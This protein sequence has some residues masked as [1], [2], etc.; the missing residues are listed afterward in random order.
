MKQDLSQKLRQELRLSPQ[1]LE[2]VK[3]LQLPRLELQQMIRQELEVNPFLA[4]DAILEVEDEEYENEIKEERDEEE[5]EANLPK[6][7]EIDYDYFYHDEWK[8]TGYDFSK[9][10]SEDDEFNPVDVYSTPKSL[11]DYMLF[12]VH[13]NFEDPTDIKVAEFITDSLDEEGMLNPAKI[14]HES[15]VE[16]IAEALCTEVDAIPVSNGCV[17]IV[18]VLA[19]EFK[20]DMDRLESI[21][22][23]YRFLEPVGVGSRNVRESLLT[24][25][26]FKNMVDTPEY[27]IIRDCFDDF[28]SNKIYKIVLKLKM[29]DLTWEHKEDR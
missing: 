8:S 11:R 26:E 9:K 25:L 13:M 29:T 19:A 1:L 14:N 15:E 17:D 7:Q 4:D 16:K 22:K 6:E 21:L 3:I 23:R 18:Y 28:I 5:N 10:S 24:Q 2:L 12:Q 27:I 20:T